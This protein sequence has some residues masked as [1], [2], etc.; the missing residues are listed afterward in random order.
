MGVFKS[1]DIR[2]VYNREW[3]K[4]LAYRIG[5]FLPAL[6]ETERILVGRDARESSEEIFAALSRGI[7]EAG[8]DVTD[9]GLCSTPSVYFATAHFEFGGSVMITASHNPPEYN[10]LKISRA[11]AIP[12]GYD[13]GL[14]RLEKMIQGA[15]VP[16]STPGKLETLD[17]RTQYLEHLAP[18]KRAVRG[19]KAVIDCSDGM[20]SV[21]IHDVIRDLQGQI[22]TMYDKPDGTFPHHPPNPLIEAN[23]ADLKRRTR[24]EKADLGICFDGDG[25]RVMF[26]DEAGR[27]I[28]PDLITALLGLYFF[29]LHG[30]DHRGEVVTYDVRTSRSVVE[31]VERLGGKPVI[32]KVGHS[33]AKKLLRDTRGIYGGELAGHYYFRDNYYCDSGVIAALLVLAIL[34]RIKR[35]FSE[36]IAEMVKYHY[37]GE[38]NFKTDAKDRI[39]DA[40]L[41]AYGSQPGAKLTDIDGI[42]MD[43]PEWWFNLRKSNTEPYL[44]L[45]AEANS[46]ERLNERVAELKSCFRE[47]DPSIEEE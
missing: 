46:A 20:A 21:F 45:V 17:I 19:I 26:I 27:F 15:V 36:L 25:D 31:Y 3:D 7:R 47:L 24:A 1:Y 13:T 5:F 33:H 43:F 11:Q 14:D 23:L 34:S 41:S 18:Y 12:V 4:D 29:R 22:I 39:I 6:L 44:R 10:G 35:P 8:C 42:R 2:G 28:S 30:R 16:A 37:S 32:C 40:V 38:I 9:I